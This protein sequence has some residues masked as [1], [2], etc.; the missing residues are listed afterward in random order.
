MRKCA[1]DMFLNQ[2]QSCSAPRSISRGV[3]IKTVATSDVVLHVR[4]F[5]ARCMTD[6][7]P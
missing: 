7:Y 1:N 3:V 4:C 2:A 6:F 5:A